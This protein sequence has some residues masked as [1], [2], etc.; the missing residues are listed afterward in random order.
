MR[1]RGLT[2]IVPIKTGKAAQ[3]KSFLNEIGQNIMTNPHIPFSQFKTVHFLRWVILPATKIG[4]ENIPE[5][6]VMSSNYDGS[7]DHHLAD[8]V[9]IAGNGIGKIYAFCEDAPSE[10]KAELIAYLKRH[11]RRNAA[12]YVGATGRKASQIHREKELWESIEDRLQQMDPS[13]QWES[14]S[15]SE[16]GQQLRKEILAEPELDWS[17]NSYRS[18]FMERFGIL[19]L[20]GGLLG[21]IGLFTLGF[22]F[23]PWITGGLSLAIVLWFTALWMALRAAEKKDRQAFK[24]ARRDA[25]RIA[26]LHHREDY[27][28]QN[29]ITHLVDIK[30]GLV[31]QFWLRFVLG[32]INLLAISVFN[33]G[34][35]GGISSIHF[36]RW[37]II[38][39]GRRLLFFSNYD[40][41]WES[42]LGEFVDRASFGL[43][44]VW[45]NTVGFPPTRKLIFEGA[46]HSTQFKA[47]VRAQQIETQI[48]YSHYPDL[49]IN[50]V[51]NNT[52]IRQGLLQK[53]PSKTAE[54]LQ[55]F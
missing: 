39:G 51:N 24:R 6:L 52:A 47:W 19:T 20:G 46:A 42:Y 4:G 33:K 43:T 10:G 27:K 35:L 16:I 26:D 28:T 53:D 1:Q 50:N 41:S 54:W 5:Q 49:S 48:W 29:Q 45:S 12:F 36:A 13:Q 38:D 14:G 17:R 30:P 3:L 18:T 23:F 40:G 44:G 34:N 22:C 8:L 9:D 7:L 21:L 55:R 37:A 11:R 31:R 32:A 15:A 2:V 25:G